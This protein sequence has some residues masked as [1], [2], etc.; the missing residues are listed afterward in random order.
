MN[1]STP[2]MPMSAS[3][4]LIELKSAA[5]D[6]AANA[7]VITD[8]AGI[9]IWVNPAFHRLT[10]Y[11]S[12]EV[13][14]RNINLLKSGMQPVSFYKTLWETILSGENW[15]G[16]IVDKRKDGSLYDENMT[17]AP[18]R[19]GHGEITHF[20]AIKQDSTK[21]D[22]AEE[23]ASMLAQAI[24]YS[25]DLIGVANLAGEFIFVNE[26]FLKMTGYPPEEII[27]KHFGTILSPDNPATIPESIA[28]RGLESTGWEGECI[29]RRRDGTDFP[30]FLNVAPVKDR[31][32]C[33]IG[34]VGIGRDI[35]L[36]K[37]A[38][39]SLRTSEEQFRQLA[40]N[41]H[42]VFFVREPEP[43]RMAYLSP[44]YEEIWGRPR[45]EAYDR[46][47]AWTESAHPEDRES[48]AGFF[49]HC[50]Q[51]FQSEMA[52]RIVRPDGS[53]RWIEARSFPVRDDKGRLIRIVGIAED[54]TVRRNIHEKLNAALEELKEQ[55]QDAAKLAELVD[56]LQSCQN[57]EEAFK[58]TGS[59]LQSMLPCTAGAL[60]ITSPS[61][62]L[63]EM[64]SSWGSGLGSA[65]AFR[66]DDCWALRRGKVHRVKGSGSP[67]QCAHVSKSIS[68]GYVCVQMTAQGETLGMLYVENSSEPS[69][70]AA[71]PGPDPVEILERKATAVCERI[72]LALANLRLRDVLRGQSIRDPLTGLFNRRFMEESLERELRRA[73]RGQQ[74][75]ALLMLDID[76]FKR[77]NDTFGHQAGDA[78]LRAFGNLLKE[79][80][81][82]QDV[83]CRY[84]GEE[85][86]FVLAGAPLDAARKRAELLREEIRQLSVRHGGQLLG[87]VTVSIG[88]A[89]FPENGAT[90]DTL[91]KAADDA[92]YR[93]KKEGRDHIVVA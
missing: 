52:Y 79:T 81:R 36:R 29:A 56:I 68:N 3:Q 26:A 41:I 64:V 82:G 16:H 25:L 77:F 19:N 86:A 7:M 70:S 65:P 4:Q 9:A 1:V 17:I 37:K 60:Y 14:G 20:I 93:A 39:E 76:H 85:F 74:P 22:Q 44:A 28:K 91:L 48:V 24:Q 31:E 57:A 72:S 89:V 66:P 50:M 35:T 80:T 83:A 54:T 58:I 34:T 10:G 15:Q 88:I 12:E 78:L 23:R 6:A 55:A 32:G 67:L 13:I 43:L 75:L 46:P 27:G 18:I 45:Q 21:Q 47:D 38:E 49:R 63:V 5:I 2:A 87:A 92:L 69:G 51:G 11:S 71:M 30:V 61:R 8:R 90:A 84:G 73:I 62:D 40:D 53:V 33:V 59:A 42:E